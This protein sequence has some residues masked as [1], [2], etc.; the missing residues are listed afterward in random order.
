MDQIAHLKYK[1]PNSPKIVVLEQELVRAEAESLVAEAQ[2]SNITAAKI[3][4][5]IIR[6]CLG[7]K[8]MLKMLLDP[9]GGIVLTNDGHAILREIEVSHPAAKSMIELSRTQDEEVGDGTTS[10]IILGM[11]L[12][13]RMR[14]K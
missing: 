6:S 3:V 12:T 10:V 14:V 7:P 2:L 1:E 5:D 11:L 9:M 4:S 8:A 13:M